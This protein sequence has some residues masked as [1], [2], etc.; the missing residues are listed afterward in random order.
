M[1]VERAIRVFDDF[2]GAVPR[3]DAGHE[4]AGAVD[5][6]AGAPVFDGED[7]DVAAIRPTRRTRA[8]A[9]HAAV[10]VSLRAE[11]E[12]GADR[13]LEVEVPGVAEEGELVL[14]VGREV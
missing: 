11:R 8:V 7:E 3:A 4:D 5:G 1:R 9:S 10:G 6:E 14:G 13:R 2:A 12:D